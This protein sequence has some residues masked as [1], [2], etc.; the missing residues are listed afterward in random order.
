M[1]LFRV[2]VA[3]GFA[4]SVG[5][6]PNPFPTHPNRG[7]QS[8]ERMSWLHSFS[9]TVRGTAAGAGSASGRRCSAQGHDVFTPT[10]TGVGER[11]HLLS[12]SEPRHAHRRRGQPDSVGRTVRRGAVRPLLR[13]LR[14]QR[15]CRPHP[16]SHW[17]A[18]LPGCV[19]ARERPVPARHAAARPKRACR[20][21]SRSSTEKAGRC[22]RFLPKCSTSTRPISNG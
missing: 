21:S 13:R 18:G 22:R 4:L 20:S 16:G 19:R 17:C 5:V 7:S 9:C 12:P 2:Y 15:R 8:D 10:L 3:L 14:D 1:A 11:S 6:L